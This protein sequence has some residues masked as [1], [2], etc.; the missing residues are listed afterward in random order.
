MPR[1]A[2]LPAE[3]GDAFTVADA[4]AVGVSRKR[5]RRPDVEHPFHRVRM[6]R[7]PSDDGDA[8]M[9]SA[10]RSDL[11]ARVGAYA[12]VMT[13][14]TFFCL[15]TAAVLHGYPL[16][17]GPNAPI[18]AAVHHPGRAPRGRGV[19]GHA[20]R[21]TLAEV[22]VVHGIR[23]TSPA[24]T[25]AMLG[26]H[27]SVGE[28]V[29]FGDALIRIPR[30]P[31]GFRPPSGPP[32]ATLD[33]LS[34]ALEAGRRVG[35]GRLREALPLLRTGSSSPAETAARLLLVDGGLPEPELDV[36]VFD[37]SCRWIGCSELAY[38]VYRVAVEYEGDHHRTSRDQWNR[39]IAK[40]QAYAE[41]GWRVVRLTHELVDRRPHEVIRQVA[42][43]L[44]AAG[45]TG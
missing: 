42:A 3:L 36:D 7:Q 14:A 2:P 39:D 24:T 31:G 22:T 33:Q 40:Y 8:G 16:R 28:L 10:R 32:L 27:L 37:A 18:H 20:V 26:A 13:D 45:W 11:R 34:R 19:H 1:R 41:V 12:L 21:P 43:A 4:A 9:F 35:A 38:R 44:R 30:H 23:V 29:A 5:L 6:R 17:M 15:H 25:W